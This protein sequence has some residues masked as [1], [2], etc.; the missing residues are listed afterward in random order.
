[1]RNFS[2]APDHQSFIRIDDIGGTPIRRNIKIG[3]GKSV[4]L[5]FRHAVRD[6]M[7]SNPL[8]VDAVV[9]SQNRVFLLARKIGEANAFFFGTSG[10]QFATM[11][12]YV[13]RETAGLESL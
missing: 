10:A 3:L 5:E 7:V 13:E 6:V 2:A 8:A 1:S 12:L 4:L 9:L 11:E